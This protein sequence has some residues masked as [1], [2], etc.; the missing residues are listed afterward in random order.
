MKIFLNLVTIILLVA[1]IILLS[2]KIAV[3]V[4]INHDGGS[5]EV[6]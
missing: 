4:I 2:K 5:N 1:D 6:A 3:N